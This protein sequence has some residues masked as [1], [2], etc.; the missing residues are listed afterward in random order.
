MKTHAELC[1][2]T[3]P[4]CP[5]RQTSIESGAKPRCDALSLSIADD[6]SGLVFSTP[7]IHEAI[8]NFSK[9]AKVDLLISQ[10]EIEISQVTEIIWWAYRVP[11]HNCIACDIYG[12][13]ST[14][15][16]NISITIAG[17]TI[18]P[19]FPEEEPFEFQDETDAWCFLA[20]LIEKFQLKHVNTISK[21]TG[22]QFSR[23]EIEK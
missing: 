3:D 2:G 14:K 7:T 8:F 22:L 15:S 19:S 1:P 20:L 12:A 17:E 21:G 11:P 4:D 9:K 10:I 16:L 18:I 5:G 23:R 6:F 13:N